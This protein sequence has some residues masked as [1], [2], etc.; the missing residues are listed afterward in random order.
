MDIDAESQVSGEESDASVEDSELASNESHSTCPV[1][2]AVPQVSSGA[3]SSRVTIEDADEEEDEYLS[4]EPCQLSPEALAEEG[5]DDLPWDPAEEI[6]PHS[7]DSSAPPERV[8]GN[9]ESTPAP[10]NPVFI[11]SRPRSLPPGIFSTH[12]GKKGR[13]H[14]K[15]NLD[16]VTTARLECMIRFLHL[17]KVSGYSGW[18]LHSETVAT[19]SGKCGLKTWLGRKIRQWAIS[20]CDDN[21]NIPNH[22]FG[23][24]NSSI[25]ADEDVAGNIHLHLQSLGNV[26]RKIKLRTAQSWMKKM[27]YRWRKEPRGM[28]SDG[29]EREDVVNYR[30][31]VFLP[32]WR[33]L[34]ARSRWWEDSIQTDEM[35]EFQARMG[36]YMSRP[37]ADARV[38]KPDAVGEYKRARKL[39]KA[40]KTHEGYQ[41]TDTIIDQSTSAMDTLDEDYSDEK[42]VF[43]YDNTTIHTARAPDALSAVTMTLKPSANFNKTK[44]SDN[45]S[46]CV[47]MRDATFR[48]GT[49]QCL[50]SRMDASRE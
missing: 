34:E 42:H 12:A 17:Y 7:A 14:A 36:V 45:V 27:G 24:F 30:Q 22:M 44:G 47:R 29:H 46:R 23:R 10:E 13:G 25:M 28:Y 6:S 39:L 35:V 38:V 32:R 16:I 19:A 21:T 50:Y 8:S 37:G 3:S 15:T 49:P 41:T 4:V 5:L 33:A 26:K 11:E 18:T 43:A 31:N 2:V 40:G 48:D 9:I 1:I 20:F